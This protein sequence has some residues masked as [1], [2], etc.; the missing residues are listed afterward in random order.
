M[1]VLRDYD[2]SETMKEV[3][4]NVEQT[5]LDEG[6]VGEGYFSGGYC[7][8]FE[9]GGRWRSRFT[10]YKLW[11]KPIWDKAR[12]MLEYPKEKQLSHLETELLEKT[13]DKLIEVI[14]TETTPASTV[15]TNELLKTL[16]EQDPDAEVFVLQE[17]DMQTISSLSEDWCDKSTITIIDYHN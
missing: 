12:E 4:S 3:D 9:T 17:C 16:K 1:Y 2:P 10:E 15:L 13:V 7:D 14:K 8:W 11:G 5:L 6:F